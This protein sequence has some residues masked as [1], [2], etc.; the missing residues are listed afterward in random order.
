MLN[1]KVAVIFDRKK[2]AKKR[3]CGKVEPRIYL[4]R[5]KCKYIS[6]GDVAAN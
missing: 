3:G 1:Q 2:E 6:F 4:G 5:K